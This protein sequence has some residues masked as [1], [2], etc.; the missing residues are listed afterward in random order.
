MTDMA[1]KIKAEIKEMILAAAG[2]AVASGAFSAVPLPGFNIESP[3]DRAHG[4]FAVNAA[5]VWAKALRRAPRA[6]A[7]TLLQNMQPNPL[8]TKVEIAGP[9]FI[10]FYLSNAYYA[11]VQRRQQLRPQQLR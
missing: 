3:A 2:Q 1:T 9:G 8:V 10:N 7:E 11:G 5:M 6:I 4:D